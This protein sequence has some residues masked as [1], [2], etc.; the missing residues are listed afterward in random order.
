MNETEAKERLVGQIRF[1]WEQGQPQF[2]WKLDLSRTYQSGE[3]KT[4]PKQQLL[5]WIDCVRSQLEKHDGDFIVKPQPTGAAAVPFGLRHKKFNFP[6][7]ETPKTP[8]ASKNRKAL[9]DMLQGMAK[10]LLLEGADT[11]LDWDLLFVLQ[12]LTWE[13]F[14]SACNGDYTAQRAL[15]HIARSAVDR[16][17]EGALLK[18][19][20]V[21]HEAEKKPWIPGFIGLAKEINSEMQGICRKVNQGNR[22]PLPLAAPGIKGKKRKASL[23]T[24]Q[25]RLVH[26]LFDHMNS[27]RHNAAIYERNRS[28]GLARILEECG[29]HVSPLVRKM[30]NLNPCS[31]ETVHEWITLSRE[32]IEDA[33]NGNPAS[34]PAFIK[35]GRFA[36]LGMPAPSAKR[37]EIKLWKRLA[38]AWNLW[39]DGM[40]PPPA[41]TEAIK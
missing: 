20:G 3:P 18:M 5:E 35:G 28:G 1:F 40:P 16:F 4:F 2:E 22:F 15:L 14:F 38:E 36:S 21:T 29:D 25:N 19:P 7:H 8:P 39:A 24:A 37:Q 27:Y 10:D 6:N 32:V 9:A 23:A 31:P 34:H 13:V 41:A 30:M 11:D 26:L 17:L 33:T 12:E